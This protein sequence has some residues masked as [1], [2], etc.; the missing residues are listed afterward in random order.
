MDRYCNCN[1][2]SRQGS[3]SRSNYMYV[4]TQ[5]SAKLLA[6]ILILTFATTASWVASQPAVP[7]NCSQPALTLSIVLFSRGTLT[8][9][10]CCSRLLPASHLHSHT[11]RC[12]SPTHCR[13][14]QLNT[15]PPPPPPPVSTE[16]VAAMA[17][18]IGHIDGIACCYSNR[19][20]SAPLLS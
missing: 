3:S 19:A 18:R 9:S 7:P 10:T 12:F 8:H 11:W 2:L 1:E 16:G 6:P 4:H 15:T 20:S 17:A 13:Y 14:T 5:V